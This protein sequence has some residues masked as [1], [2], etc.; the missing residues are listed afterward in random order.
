M[1]N[2]G[3][4]GIFFGNSPGVVGLKG[5]ICELKSSFGSF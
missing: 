2:A 5:F 4:L 3:N 1:G